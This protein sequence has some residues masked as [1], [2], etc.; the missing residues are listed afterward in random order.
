MHF[1]L[2][3]IGQLC[4]IQKIKSRTRAASQYLIFSNFLQQK[5]F[6]Q[7][8]MIY[9]KTLLMCRQWSLCMTHKSSFS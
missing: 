4:K 3:E 8:E 7:I 2:Y 1:P 5:Y 9:M 6:I